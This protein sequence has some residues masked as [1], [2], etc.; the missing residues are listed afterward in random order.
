MK[1]GIHQRFGIANL[2]SLV[3]NLGAYNIGAGDD[4]ADAADA[5][6]AD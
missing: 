5:D 3:F 4:G 2:K 1:H 6:V